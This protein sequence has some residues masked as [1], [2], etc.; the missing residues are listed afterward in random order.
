MNKELLFRRKTVYSDVDLI[1]K[2][3]WFKNKHSRIPRSR[4]CRS[5]N[6]MP[7]DSIYFKRFGSFNNAIEMAGLP[8]SKKHPNKNRTYTDEQLFDFIKKCSKKIGHIPTVS[9]YVVHR[10]KGYP[11]LNTFLYRFGKFE[12]ALEQ[13]GIKFSRTKYNLRKSCGHLYEFI[14]KISRSLREKYD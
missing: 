9:E 1:N 8:I 2:L 3:I 11:T 10:E 7:D 13:S 14:R 5:E 6:D 12:K 4:D